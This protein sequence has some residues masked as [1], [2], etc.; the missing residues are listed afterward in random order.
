MYTSDPEPTGLNS[1]ENHL[2]QCHDFES[3]S[4]KD[5]LLKAIKE[6]GFQKCTPI[7]GKV[8]PYSLE[9]KDIVGKAQTGTGKTAAFLLT[10]LNLILKPTQCPPH[11]KGFSSYSPKALILAPTRELVLQITQDGK[12]LAKYTQIKFAP[13]IGGV[14]YRKQIQALRDKPEIIVATPGRLIDFFKNK[15][16]TFYQV[17]FCV[18]DEADR[19]FD[20]GFYPDLK[21]LLRKMPP[22]YKRQT[23]LFSATLTYRVT[24]LSYEFMNQPFEIDVSPTKMTVEKVKEIIYHVGM[25]EKLPLFLGLLKKEFNQKSII[26]CNTKSACEWLGFK[27]NNNGFPTKVLTGD[28]SQRKRLN[29]VRQF[30]ES[31]NGFLVAT[32]VA[33]RGLHVDDVTHVFNYDVPEDPENYIH[34]IGRTARAGREGSAITLA[35]ERYVMSLQQVEDLIGHKIPCESFSDEDLIIDQA[36]PFQRKIGKSFSHN[37]NYEKS[38]SGKYQKPKGSKNKRKRRK[39]YES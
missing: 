29:I 22:F 30:K 14:D 4:L 25:A 35:C 8:L 19:M 33:S 24:D 32:D 26:F 6:L 23:L 34:R 5:A 28:V 38:K 17:A 16:I 10:V 3:L 18:I 11:K 21:Y 2:V 13:I 31:A 7:Q 36:G 9:G 1:E 15:K 20:M 37:R 12:N 27:L 39:Q